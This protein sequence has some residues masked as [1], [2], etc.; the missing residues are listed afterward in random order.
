MVER[1]LLLQSL[2]ATPIQLAKALEKKGDGWEATSGEWSPEQVLAH[3]IDV[4]VRY[5]GR[6]HR[7]SLEQDPRLALIQPDESAHDLQAGRDGLLRRFE[8]ARAETLDFVKELAPAVWQRTAI[9]P[10][11]G[12]VTFQTLVQN[13]IEHDRQHLI[14]IIEYLASAPRREQQ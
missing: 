13:L 3:L 12:R 2:A 6:L 11:W 4:E 10:T 7:V 14:Q 1:I 5:L 9:H 8:A